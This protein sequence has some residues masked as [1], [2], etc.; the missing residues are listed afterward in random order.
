MHMDEV[1][2]P[3][4]EVVEDVRGVDDG[5]VARLGLLLQPAE[6]LGATED[7]EVDGNLVE[8]E[9]GPGS[10]EAHGELHATSL[11]VAD[12]AHAPLHV[13]IENTDQLIAALG[14]RVA[15]DRAEEFCDADVRPHDGVQNP[16]E[17][18]VCDALEALF[19]R[20]HAADADAPA[21]REALAGQ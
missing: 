7:V 19:E 20:V 4:G 17:A 18:K 13:D 1:G 10:H 21:G 11:A 14:V 2:R 5:A 3:A 6:E 8:E 12:G 16:F 15:A 9:H